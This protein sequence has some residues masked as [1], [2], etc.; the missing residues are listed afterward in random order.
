MSYYG[1]QAGPLLAQYYD[2]WARDPDLGYHVRSGTTRRDREALIRQ[3]QTLIDPAIEVTGLLRLA[4]RNWL[5]AEAKAIE[6]KDTRIN[7][8][9]VRDDLDENSL[10][11]D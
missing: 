3:R 7:E 2:Q 11:D 9:E 1:P 5:D 10:G 6:A 8:A 4:V